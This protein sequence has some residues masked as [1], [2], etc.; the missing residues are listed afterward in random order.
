MTAK[1]AVAARRREP[2]DRVVWLALPAVAYLVAVYG[3]PL[4]VLLARGVT[5]PTGLTL[6]PFA[7]FFADPFHWQ[8]VANTIKIAAPVT[9]ACPLIGYPTAFALAWSAGWSRL[10]L[11]AAIILPLSVGVVVK[12]FAWQC[13][14]AM[15]WSPWRWSSS[16][17]GAS[18]FACC[19]PRPDSCWAPPMCFCRS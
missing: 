4:L 19:S 9:L 18:P 12:A 13:C 6:A 11:L 15:A 17:S 7:A 14:A 3:W 8:V 5:G 16:A 10:V 2:V 1:L